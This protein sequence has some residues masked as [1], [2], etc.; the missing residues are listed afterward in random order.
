MQKVAIVL[1]IKSFNGYD[2]IY[3]EISTLECCHF[4]LYYLLGCREQA[5]SI[6]KHIDE[7]LTR[8]KK[9]AIVTI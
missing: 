5:C 9:K 2:Y 6:I 7:N 8:K 3:A 4:M 1:Q